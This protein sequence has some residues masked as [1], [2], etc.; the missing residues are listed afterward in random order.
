[1]RWALVRVAVATT[2]MVALAFLVPL[3]LVVQQIARDRALSDAERQTSTMTTVLAVTTDRERLGH[4]LESS[5]G[6]DNY[7]LALYLPDGAPLGTTHADRADVALASTS[8]EPVTADVRGGIVYLQSVSIT[9]GSVAVIEVFLPSKSLSRGVGTAWIALSAVALALVAGSVVVADRLGSKVVRSARRLAEAARAFGS[10]DLRVRVQPAGPPELVAVGSAFNAMAAQ[11]VQLLDGER[12]LAADLSHRLRTPLTA[13]RLDAESLDDGA[14][15]DRI[16]MAVGTLER[17]VDAIIRTAR[18]PLAERRVGECD[19]ADVLAERL[20]FWSALAEDEGRP[21]Q[22]IGADGV[23]AMV[24][25][26][27]SEMVAV[28][29]ALLGNVFRHTPQGVGFV[30]A[31]VRDPHGVTVTV[32]DA[33]PGFVNPDLALLRG[34]SEGGSTGLGLDIARR[35]AADTGGDIHIGRSRHGGACISLWLRRNARHH[36]RAENGAGRHQTIKPRSEV[37]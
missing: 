21:W 14:D 4:A 3:G 6:S 2:T 26:P 29:D 28:V 20:G 30:V 1:M 33:G 37:P 34:R 32:D 8:T 27:R 18:K 25:V 13:L 36:T 5:V 22:L 35:V 12:E 16:R 23:P 31:M 19:V 7:Q 10:G 11:V 24:P 15:G 9:A 17:E